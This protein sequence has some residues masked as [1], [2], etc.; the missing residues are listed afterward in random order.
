MRRSL[1]D[2]RDARVVPDLEQRPQRL[3]PLL[4]LVLL[5]GRALHHRP[6]L[7]HPELAL[8]DPDP[9]VAEE[10]GPAGVELDRRGDQ[11]P[12]RQPDEDDDPADDEVERALHG[13]VGAGQDRRAQLEERNA[14]AGHVLAALHEQLGRPRRQPDLH[15]GPVRDLDDLEHGL[16]VE[17]ALV[18]D[19]FVRAV[20]LD[21]ARELIAPARHERADELVGKSSFCRGQH[22][23]ER[24]QALALPDEQHAGARPKQPLQL[25]REGV[26]RGPERPD[27]EHARRRRRSG[28]GPKS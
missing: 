18:Q 6:E 1:A 14:L 23:L 4:E 25:G 26:V 12:Q 13:P 22:A 11:Q 16:L 24:G 21:P 15:S 3:V 9:A 7:E 10:H 20:P 28:P 17:V 19:H 27:Q 2:A 5:R 8:A